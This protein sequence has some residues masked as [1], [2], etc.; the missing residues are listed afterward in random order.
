MSG[1]PDTRWPFLAGILTDGGAD[2]HTV[3]EYFNFPGA[4]KTM[5][6]Q[7]SLTVLTGLLML[8]LPLAAA[9]TG[10]EEYEIPDHGQLIMDVPVKWQ[11][12]FYQPENEGF[13]VISF[14]PFEGDDGFKDTMNF[15]L[16]VA[17]FW[18]QSVA[19]D[20][21][22]PNNLRQFVRGVGEDVLPQSDQDSL[23][24]EEIVGHSGVG[25]IFD[26]T[27][28]AAAENEYPYLTQGALSIGNVVV[29]FSLFARGDEDYEQIRAQTLEMLKTAKQDMSRRD[30]HY[31]SVD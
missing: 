31:P 18:S 7:L 11:A 28:M 29:V 25:Y 24:L 12:T 6:R 14:Y 13:P 30:V 17:V 23:D 27:N 16:S 3:Q 19:H 2:R 21:T 15:Q 22:A 8:A 20:L 9:E 26:L 5:Q 4:C 10:R 1:T